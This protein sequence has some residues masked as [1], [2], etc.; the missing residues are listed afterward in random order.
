[1]FPSKS[2]HG[3]QG[4]RPREK[5]PRQLPQ[6]PSPSAAPSIHRES[7]SSSGPSLRVLAGA[8]R[9]L[10][11]RGHRTQNEFQGTRPAATQTPTWE[12]LARGRV[13]EFGGW[14]TEEPT[15]TGK[16]VRNR[17]PR[18]KARS[19]LAKFE[20]EPRG[21][22]RTRILDNALGITGL[23]GRCGRGRWGGMEGPC[24]PGWE[25]G[26]RAAPPPQSGPQAPRR[27]R[28]HLLRITPA[29]SSLPPP[30]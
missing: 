29:T 8:L 17:K 27:P 3:H 6:P 25:P 11:S 7:G 13:Y 12:T 20:R 23:V 10:A 14:L 30:N 22:D 16:F 4:G 15:L 24:A 18:E 28:P 1:M 19:P 9:T 26:R 21:P 2:G 5:R